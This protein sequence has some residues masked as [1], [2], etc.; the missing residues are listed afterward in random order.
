MAKIREWL[1]YMNGADSFT[2]AVPPTTQTALSPA[3]PYP[4]HD[5][6]DQISHLQKHGHA[7]GTTAVSSSARGR[8]PP[9]PSSTT[10]SALP[11]SRPLLPPGRLFDHR[12][13]TPLPPSATLRL[14]RLAPV[15]ASSPASFVAPPPLLLLLSGKIRRTHPR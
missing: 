11:G 4:H 9:P 6:V 13:A 2:D 12:L 15:P 7:P 5:A 14:R 3:L 1:K 8:P 10:A